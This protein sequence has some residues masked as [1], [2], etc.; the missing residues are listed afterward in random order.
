MDVRSADRV[1][2]GVVGKPFGVGGAAYVRPDPDVAH[3]F[4]PGTEYETTDTTLRVAARHDHGARMILRFEGVTT[5][6]SAE[7]LRGTVLYADRASVALDEDTWW[8]DDVVGCEVVDPEG[9]VVGVVE[10]LADGPAHDYLVVARPDAGVVWVP[11]VSELVR[12]EA[13]RV[14][15]TPVPGLLDPD[16]AEPATASPD[17]AG[18]EE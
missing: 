16:E 12:I 5:R 14:I 11:A 9:A 13:D 17:V 15:V 8:A 1:V 4:A 3:D 10:R 7:A 2:V 6:D 18:T